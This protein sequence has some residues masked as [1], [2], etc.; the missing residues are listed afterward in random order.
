VP[1][2]ADAGRRTTLVR[3]LGWFALVVLLAAVLSS[4]AVVAF[5]VTVSGDSMQPTLRP[6]DRLVADVLHR[7]DVHRF[8]VVEAT[9]GAAR[10]PVVKRVVGLPGDRILVRDNAGRRE[11]LVRPAG[12]TTVFR[13]VSDTWSSHPAADDEA[14]CDADGRSRPRP[15][16]VVVPAD[17]YWLIGDNWG[18]STDSR[19]FGFVRARDIGARLAFRL[20][21]L[22]DV[23]RLPEPAHLVATD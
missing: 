16:W 14:C 15:A 20:T 9:V 13:V 3:A 6:G 22:G 8:D 5:S 19:T 2:V 18:G 11:V 4:V 7:V 1:A 10:T 12:S 17:A 23:G 21:P